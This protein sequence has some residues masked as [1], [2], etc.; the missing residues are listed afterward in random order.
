M[1]N[2]R[3]RP[4]E[5]YHAIEAAACRRLGLKMV[6]FIV[7]SRDAPSRQRVVGAKRL[8]ETVEYPALMHCKSG[9]DRAGMMSVLYMHF[10]KGR[11]IREALDQ[12]HLRYLHVKQGM[13]GVLDYVFERYLS[14]GEPAGLSF[15]E[16]V[17]S[18]MYDPAGLKS[19]FR[20]DVRPSGA[21]E[22]V[23]LGNVGAA[24]DGGLAQTRVIGSESSS[25]RTSPDA[26]RMV[27]AVD[28]TLACDETFYTLLGV[29]PDGVASVVDLVAAE[30]LLMAR[31]R[32]HAL[33]RE[34]Q[35]CK[36]VEVWCDGALVEQLER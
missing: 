5:S 34:H 1:I 32:A 15:L 31:R 7:D 21:E 14:E 18:P 3:G 13:T 36:L 12:L 9:A 2:L 4:Y 8:F 24:R 16:W 28:T 35:S 23:P 29:R 19:Q 17:Q 27:T 20:P 25:R 10:R 6:D 26:R 30:D 11:T 33:L 22:P